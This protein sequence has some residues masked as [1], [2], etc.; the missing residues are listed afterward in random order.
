VR[1]DEGAAA[2]MKDVYGNLPI[3]LASRSQIFPVLVACTKNLDEENNKGETALELAVER[4]FVQDVAILVRS[5]R[6]DLTRKSK[7][8]Y[9]VL[10]RAW[11]WG[12]RDEAILKLLESSGQ[13]IAEDMRPKDGSVA[14]DT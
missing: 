9:T 7:S 6:V 10:D 2:N 4:N 1:A 3:H 5:G 11:R 14:T 12:N 8:G 13:T